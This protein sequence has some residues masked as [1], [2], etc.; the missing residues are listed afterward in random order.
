MET[1]QS[2]LTV[3]NFLQNIGEPLHRPPSKN[4]LTA[5]NNCAKAESLDQE[6]QYKGKSMHFSS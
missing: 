5:N 3:L 4:D 1:Y 2:D 6:P